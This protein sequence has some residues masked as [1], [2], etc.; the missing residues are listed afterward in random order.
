MNQREPQRPVNWRARTF[1]QT[2]PWHAE[3]CSHL[4]TN[5]NRT[6]I[7]AHFKKAFPSTYVQTADL[8]RPIIATIARV[9]TETV[10]VG[11]DAETKPV[12]HFKEPGLKSLVLNLTKCEA[13][14]GIAKSE[15]MDDWPGVRIQLSQGT[16]YYKTKKVACIVVSPAPPL[17]ET[18][19]F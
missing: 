15:E 8:D 1:L 2:A 7:M 4:A 6:F 3:R 16:T 18:G 17:T 13:I 10:G 14:A 9:T 19:G 11:T 5:K 12:A